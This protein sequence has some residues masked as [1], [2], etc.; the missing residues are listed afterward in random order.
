[1][2]HDIFTR[3]SQL[4]ARFVAADA[5]WREAMANPRFGSVD[6]CERLYAE[7]LCAEDQVAA[8]E[9]AI[10]AWASARERVHQRYR[11]TVAP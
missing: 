6:E 10:Q 7:M 4:L 1:M 3:R 8:C 9:E 11:E 5:A 2:I